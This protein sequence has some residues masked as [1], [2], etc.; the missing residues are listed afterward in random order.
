M[1]TAALGNP[2]QTPF[3]PMNIPKMDVSFRP[4]TQSN[5]Y[6]Q[7]VAFIDTEEE[8]VINDDDESVGC[9][10]E[11]YKADTIYSPTTAPVEP[12]DPFS[13]GGDPIKTFYVGSI[14]VLG[15]YLLY[16]IL[17]RTR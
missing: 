1:F 15:L 5:G 4:L 11:E 16:K 13:L 17:N 10:E 12:K 3:E 8:L 7:Y 14:T 9:Q 2:K 6:K